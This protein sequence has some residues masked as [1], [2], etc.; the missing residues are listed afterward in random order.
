MLKKHFK[1]VLFTVIVIAFNSSKKADTL[2]PFQEA[3]LLP[4]NKW[5]ALPEVKL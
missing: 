1:I 3:V 2:V 4:L 5:T